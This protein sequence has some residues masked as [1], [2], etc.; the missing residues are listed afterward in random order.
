[1]DADY[2][3]LAMML[4]YKT[5]TTTMRSYERTRDQVDAIYASERLQL[6]FKG[7]CWSA[8]EDTA[9]DEHEPRT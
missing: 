2:L 6:P 8:I 5:G 7:Y 4:E 9:L 1:M 3:I